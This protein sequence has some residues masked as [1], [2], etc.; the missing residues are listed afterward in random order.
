MGF[1]NLSKKSYVPFL[2]QNGWDGFHQAE[3]HL[4]P[5]WFNIPLWITQKNPFRTN[6]FGERFSKVLRSDLTPN[7]IGSGSL[8]KS[9][10]TQAK[11]R[12]VEKNKRRRKSGNQIP[13]WKR[14]IQGDF[15]DHKFSHIFSVAPFR[16]SKTSRSENLKTLRP[17]LS[18]YSSLVL[19]FCL[20]SLS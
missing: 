6:S 20:A 18:M 7:R 8:W 4:I 16:F 12:K 10:M 3:E 15:K 19:S 9:Q 5:Q 2:G 11:K 17:T 13:L 14:G 1:V